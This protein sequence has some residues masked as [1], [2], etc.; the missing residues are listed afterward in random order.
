[1]TPAARGAAVLGLALGC[2]HALREPAPLPAPRAHADGAADLLRRADSAWA[3]R[4]DP[5][6]ARTAQELYTEAASADPSAVDGLLGAMRAASFRIERERDGSRREELAVE[7][8]QLGQWCQRRAPKD[9]AC[10]YRLAIAL[11]QQARERTSTGKDAMGRM[12][13]LL[14]RAIAAAP[15]LDGAGPHRVLALLLVRAPGWPLGPGDAEAALA[16]ARDAVKLFPDRADNQLV[17]G[18]AL[19]KNDAPKDA[20]AAYQRA[21]ELATAAREAG[22]PDAER[23]LEDAAAALDR[24]GK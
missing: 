5:D 7:A 18:E 3:R 12:V 17:L 22:D 4:A 19:A 2:A 24:L 15:R 23:I 1:M 21:V 6:E 20:R 9:P 14:H 16:E 13:D 10:A 11:G 8:V